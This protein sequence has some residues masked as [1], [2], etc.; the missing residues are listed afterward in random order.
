M[1]LLEGRVAVVTGSG[2]G[3]GRAVALGLCGGG[4]DGCR[5]RPK[6]G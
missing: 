4:R 3:V 2:R 5:D 1:S 6:S